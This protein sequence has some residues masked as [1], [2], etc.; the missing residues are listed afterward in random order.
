MNENIVKKLTYAM[1]LIVQRAPGY[2]MR[3]GSR[4]LK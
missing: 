2:A 4:L 3:Y 1:K